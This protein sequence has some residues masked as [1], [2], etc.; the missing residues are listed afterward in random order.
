MGRIILHPYERDVR[1]HML[2]HPSLKLTLYRLR[3]L[4]EDLSQQRVAPYLPVPVGTGPVVLELQS[5]GPGE[6][7]SPA[8]LSQC[9]MRASHVFLCISMICC[10]TNSSTGIMG[11]HISLFLLVVFKW[12]FYITARGGHGCLAFPFSFHLVSCIIGNS[13]D[14]N[15]GVVL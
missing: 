15:E 2:H 12:T 8:M 3:T 6:M 10:E 7:A 4:L 1:Q 9:K 11:L 13:S 14:V 5:L